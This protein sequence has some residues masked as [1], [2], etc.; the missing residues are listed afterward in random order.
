MTRSAGRAY[1]PRVTSDSRRVALAASAFF[2]LLFSYSMLRPVRDA[3][4][5]QTGAGKLQWLFTGTFIAT[6]LVIPI[7]GWVVRNVRRSRV[8]P[9]V[10]TFIILNL[11]VF[12]GLFLKGITVIEAASFFIW[13]SVVNLFLISLFWSHV[14]DTFTTEES[15]RLYAYIAAGGS[16]GALSGPALTALIAKRVPTWSLLAMSAVLLTIA[17]IC[18]TFVRYRSDAARDAAGEQRI[19]GSIFAGFRLAFQVPELRWLMLL[20]ICYTG[21][22]TVLYIEQAD[23]VGKMFPSRGEQTAFF[24]KV[25]LIINLSALAFQ[26]IGTRAVVKRFGLRVA[27]PVVPL[28]VGIALLFGGAWKTAIVLAAIQVLHR[29]GDFALVRPGRE[30]IYT[31]V[32]AESRFKAKPFIDTTVYRANDV[33]SSWLIT[34]VRSA[35]VN[36]MYFVGVPLAILWFMTGLFIGRR[37]DENHPA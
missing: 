17:T 23:A 9:I 18:A 28:I 7:I 33:A 22:S 3:M 24:A 11:L 29:A 14:S 35:G 26:L 12:L 37:H 2:F 31:T 15:H 19:G 16:A 1:S 5:V 4:G 27:L 32:D 30:M 36:A 6:I 34:A 25:D 21:V 8:L 20:I 13:L 10:Y